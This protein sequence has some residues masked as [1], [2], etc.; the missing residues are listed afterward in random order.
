M[1]AIIFVMISDLTPTVF[2]GIP[3]SSSKLN[4][5]RYIYTFIMKVAYPCIAYHSPAHKNTY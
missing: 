4:T 2:D 5:I 3:V 1:L